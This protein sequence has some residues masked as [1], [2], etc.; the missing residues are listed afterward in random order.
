MPRPQK[1]L[2]PPVA[3]AFV[4]SQNQVLVLARSNIPESVGVEHWAPREGTELKL[5]YHAPGTKSTRDTACT[6][7]ICGLPYSGALRA[8]TDEE[9]PLSL[10]FIDLY[11]G[12]HEIEAYEETFSFNNEQTAAFHSLRQLPSGVC[13]IHVPPPRQI[14][15]GSLGT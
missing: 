9:N 15:M 11:E 2:S 8:M 1:W 4:I 5:S 3:I 14:T 13:L 7:N 12:I 10:P 6:P